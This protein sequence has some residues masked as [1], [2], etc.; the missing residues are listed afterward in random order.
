[1]LLANDRGQTYVN[2]LKVKNKTLLPDV[3]AQSFVHCTI[4]DI[5]I[6]LMISNSWDYRDRHSQ[7]NIGL[8]NNSYLY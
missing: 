3:C 4:I 7:I 8:N 2:I 5:M 6:H 1:M